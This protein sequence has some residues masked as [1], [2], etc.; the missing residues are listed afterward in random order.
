[1]AK[2][3][4]TKTQA[5]NHVIML[6]ELGV[7]ERVFKTI[8]TA[9]GPV[10]NCMYIKLNPDVLEKLTFPEDNSIPKNIGNSLYKKADVSAKINT[11]VNKI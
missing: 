11:P 8:P 1:M 9:C 10:P 3:N 4:I 2:L 7:I 6:E 5:R